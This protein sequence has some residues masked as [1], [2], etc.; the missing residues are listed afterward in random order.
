MNKIRY[1]VVSAVA[2]QM[3]VTAKIGDREVQAMVTG[4]TVEMQSEDGAMCHT[5]RFMDGDLTKAAAAKLEPGAI[6][7]ASF[8]IEE[9]K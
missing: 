9:S 2:E 6:V 4:H 1:R 7:V 8:K 5:F 3:P